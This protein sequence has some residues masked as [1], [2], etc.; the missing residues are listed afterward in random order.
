MYSYDRTILKT[1]AH[2]SIMMM[3]SY[4]VSKKE[5]YLYL[6]NKLDLMNSSYELQCCIYDL[7]PLLYIRA[8]EVHHGV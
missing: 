8:C 5:A 1:F 2:E 6:T 4:N 7:D 3:L